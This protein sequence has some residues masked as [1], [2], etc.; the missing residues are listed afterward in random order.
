MTTERVAIGGGSL[1]APAKRERGIA[2]R[3]GSGLAKLPELT[4]LVLMIAL[5]LDLT[6]GVFTRYVTKDTL[7]WYTEVAEFLL[8]WLVM[9]GAAVGA[10]QGVHFRVNTAVERLPSRWTPPIPDVAMLVFGLL[11][12]WQ[13]T[14]LLD[15]TRAQMSP[16][17][18][19]PMVVAYAALP[20]GGLLIAV[21]AGLRLM[22]R[23]TGSTE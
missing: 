14:L 1:S 2:R 19:L 12:A 16:I 4:L 6:A 3:L 15:V 23:T 7:A 20:A 9:I 5:C 21:F 22:R 10:K 8:V 13:G 18:G 17:L 11:F